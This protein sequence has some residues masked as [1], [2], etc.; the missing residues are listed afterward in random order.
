MNLLADAN[1]GRVYHADWRVIAGVVGEVD[2]LIVDAPYSEKTHAGHNDGPTTGKVGNPGYVN[3]STGQIEQ[4]WERRALSYAAFTTADVRSFVETW[5]P[6][7]RGWFVSITD[8]VL[9]PIW[10]AELARVGRYVFAPLPYVAPGSRVR[11]TG[12]GPSAWTCWII[13]ARPKSR[14]YSTWGTL[15]GAYV[16]PPGC[17]E[18]MSVVGGKPS[19]LM[20]RLAEDYSRPGDLVC[21]PCCGAGTTLVGAIRTGRRA[22]GGDIDRA[23]AELAAARIREERQALLLP[24]ATPTVQGS[25]L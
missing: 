2:A 17:A 5:S 21:D 3:S 14:A 12:D 19:W 10:Q 16:L 22:A 15:P 8:D 20:E 1:G 13:V 23:H 11:L 4:G 24:A 6:L 25:L 18:R 9:A 7:T